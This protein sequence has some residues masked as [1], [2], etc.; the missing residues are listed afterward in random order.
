[1]GDLQAV[2]FIAQLLVSVVGAEHV[3]HCQLTVVVGR[4]GLSQR[5]SDPRRHEL[6]KL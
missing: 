5:S 4:I 3:G 2:W 1:M 6:G